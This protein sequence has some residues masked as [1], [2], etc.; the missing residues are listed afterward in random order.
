M[1][2]LFKFAWRDARAGWGQLAFTALAIVAGVAALAAT[3]SLGRNIRE[4]IDREAR[5]LLGADLVVEAR[6]AMDDEA[7]A[8]L[9]GLGGER[10]E[11]IAFASMLAVPADGAGVAGSRLVTVRAVDAA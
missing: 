3:G 1:I 6:S 7:R 4:A 9:R 10:A 5:A 11:E 2:F 8:Y